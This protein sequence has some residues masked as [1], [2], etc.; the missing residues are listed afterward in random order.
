MNTTKTQIIATLG[1]ATEDDIM[2][3]YLVKAGVAIF[4]LNLSH[5]KREWHQAMIKKIKNLK[6][7]VAILLDTRG[8]EIRLGN[9]KENI[10]IKKNEY[11]YLT[12]NQQ[13]YNPVRKIIPI[14]YQ[15]IANSL[16]KGD[17]VAIDGGMLFA[18][19]IAFDDQL[20]KL[21]AN[22]TWILTKKRHV[23]LPGERVDLPT[24]T[25]KDLEDVKILTADNQIDYLALSFT[26]SAA[27][28]VKAKKVAGQT[29]IIAKIENFEGVAAFT[30]I[31]EES[32]GVMIARGDLG[33]EMPLERI[34]ILQK[35]MIKE[36]KAL[37]KKVIV[38][39]EMLESM[40]HS[41]RPT[42]AEVS[43]IAN[44]VWEGADYVMLSGETTI[45]KYPVRAVEIM[46]KIITACEQ[47][48]NRSLS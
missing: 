8:P 35:K 37:H 5:G 32:Y 42:R 38:A 6:Q 16:K 28:I 29:N 17:L 31:A 47:E 27:D 10:T 2:L 26:R 46:Q 15:K 30:K 9:F 45:G 20:I 43:D 18:E 21:K 14:S 7:K 39:T 22:D 19:V 11:F 4:R 1:P 44:A 36:G 34:P 24:L 48:M 41:P 12:A 3:E 40:I 13:D 23:N 25:T 33:V